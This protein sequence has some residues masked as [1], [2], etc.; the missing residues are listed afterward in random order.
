[1]HFPPGTEVKPRLSSGEKYFDVRRTRIFQYL[2]EKR[3]GSWGVLTLAD[4]RFISIQP[5]TENR[6]RQPYGNKYI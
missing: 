1:M 5:I 4:R 3:I 6:A 2:L